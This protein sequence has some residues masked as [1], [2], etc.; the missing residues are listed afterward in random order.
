MGLLGEFLLTLSGGFQ[1][2]DSGE[3]ISILEHLSR[4]SR[5]NLSVKF[6]SQNERQSVSD[7]QF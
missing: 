3:V 5:F 7:I 2:G 6:L 4:T 1:D